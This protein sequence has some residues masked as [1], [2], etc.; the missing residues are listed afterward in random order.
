MSIS[1]DILISRIGSFIQPNKSRHSNHIPALFS[2]MNLSFVIRDILF[3]RLA[4][5]GI[6]CNPGP[7]SNTTSNNGASGQGTLNGRG[8]NVVSAY[9]RKSK[10]NHTDKTPLTDQ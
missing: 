10:M 5:H 6:E 8:S 9:I 7:R 4:V 1:I 3:L 2:S